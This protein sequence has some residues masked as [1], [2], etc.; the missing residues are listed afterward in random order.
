MKDK[1]TAKDE[2]KPMELKKK[3][4]SVIF[5]DT[6]YNCGEEGH[7]SFECTQKNLG[8]RRT[9][10]VNENIQNEPESE[11]LLVRRTFLCSKE[12]PFRGVTCSVFCASL[13]VNYVM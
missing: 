13:E 7:H 3:M 1:P 12:E 5:K 4:G 9:A 10:M 11:K 2:L 8:D 6:S